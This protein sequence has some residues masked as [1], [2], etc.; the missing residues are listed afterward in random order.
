MKIIKKLYKKIL[1]VVISIYVICI[2][3]SQQ[4][5]LNRYQKEINE[6]DEQIEQAK[7]EK[8]SLLEMKENV[9][10]KISKRK[11]WNVFTK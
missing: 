8:D 9:N 7:E 10:S 1:L 6:Y 11:T 5:T 3:T 4:Q 2:F